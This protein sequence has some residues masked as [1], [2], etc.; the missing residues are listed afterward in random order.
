MRHYRL[1]H[2]IEYT[3]KPKKKAKCYRHRQRAWEMDD[4]LNG[5]IK[6]VSSAHY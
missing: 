4:N 3:V 5:V 1:S 2:W 6:I